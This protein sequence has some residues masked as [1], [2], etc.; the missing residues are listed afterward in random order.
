MNHPST[1]LKPSTKWVAAAAL[2]LVSIASAQA[3]PLIPLFADVG[4]QDLPVVPEPSTYAAC[5]AVVL[6]GLA[7]W[8]LRAR[9]QYA[10]IHR[11]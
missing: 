11:R 3:S 1:F 6:L 4:N 8:R 2:A 5:A 7:S 9:V 10:R